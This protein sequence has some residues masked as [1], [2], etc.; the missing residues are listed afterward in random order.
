MTAERSPIV[1]LGVTQ[2]I[3]YGTLYYAFSILAA[4]IGSR[5]SVSHCAFDCHFPLA[6]RVGYSGLRLEPEANI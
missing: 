3:G 1:A 4:D 5:A 6:A 2:I